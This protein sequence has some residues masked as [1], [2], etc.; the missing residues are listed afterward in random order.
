[1]RRCIDYRELNRVTMKNRYPLPRIDVMFDQFQGAVVFSK[2][3]LRS[4]YHQLKVKDEDVQKTTFR[5]RYG[6]YEFFV[7]SFGL[8]N[9]PAV[10]MDLMNMDDKVI[11][12][13]SRQMKFHE[14]NYPTHD[15]ALA[16]VVFSLKLWRNYLYGEKCHIFTDH[17][18]IKYFFTQ[19]ELNMR[20]RRWLELVKGYNYDTSYHT[21]KANVVADALSRNSAALNRLT[22]QQELISDFER[23]NLEVSEPMEYAELYIREIVRLHRI[24]A[25]IVSDRDPKFTSNFWGSLHGGLGTKLVF[26]TAFHPQ[27]DG[28]L[29][30]V[31]QILKDMLR[32]CMIDFGGNWES[33]LPLVEVIYNNSYQTTISMAPYEEFYGRRCR[34]PLHWDEVSPWKGV[35]R[36]GNRGKLS[37]RYIG[38]FEILEKVGARAYRVALPPNLEGVHNVFHISMLRKYMAN[39]SHDICHDPVEWTPDL[40][41]EEMSVQILDR[42]VRRLR[43]REIPMVKVIW[44]NQLV[45]EATWETK[46][47]M[48]ARYSELFGSA[49]WDELRSGYPK[50]GSL[51]A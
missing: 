8:T 46:Q 42:Q 40:S 14:K 41:Y 13:A 26:S 12:Y 32:A 16:A 44:R 39:P 23:M 19:K 21:G 48:R 33:K 43:N 7:M 6:H 20:Q 38:S 49:L 10:F 1:M 9:A 27:T 37:P 11:A 47:G 25:R 29:E 31:N 45:E 35:M 50:N 30:R 17:K 18:I 3:D 4:G 36:F 28:Q 24:P 34:T 22:V 2:I 51:Q 15:L 5:T